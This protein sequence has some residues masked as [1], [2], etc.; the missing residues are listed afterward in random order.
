M[1]TWRYS[2]NYGPDGEA[3][4]ANVHAAD[5]Q[6]VGNLRTHHAI[7]ICNAFAVCDK[8]ASIPSGETG[9]QGWDGDVGQEERYL[10]NLLEDDR[11]TAEDLHRAMNRIRYRQLS[12]VPRPAVT[13]TM[14]NAAWNEAKDRRMTGLPTDF[15][16]VLEAALTDK[17]YDAM[18]S[19][20]PAPAAGGLEA[21]REALVEAEAAFEAIRIILVNELEEPVRG[22]FWRAV[23]ARD[24]SRAALAAAAASRGEDWRPVLTG[25]V[26]AMNKRDSDFGDGEIP[27][28]HR[29]LMWRAE[30]LL[31]SPAATSAETQDDLVSRAE[32][33]RVIRTLGDQDADLALYGAADNARA[34]E[35]GEA[36]ATR[37]CC[38]IALMPRALASPAETQG[39]DGVRE[40]LAGLS[41]FDHMMACHVG[42][43]YFDGTEITK[44]WDRLVRPA[45]DRL[46]SQ[47]APST[48]AA[49][50]GGE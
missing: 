32:V 11:L 23:Q 7:A 30:Q 46:K 20:T 31:A 9:A 16:A 29:S 42:I 10:L 18:L 33:I 24:A 17:L 25:M 34:R 6:F 4:Y 8:L 43:G 26:A 1:T 47:L 37:A 28:A 35:Y 40:M 41:D 5:G 38:A 45:M 50:R 15:R 27:S 13:T 36:A 39:G 12:G 22:A 44:E 21:V 19:A 14:V 2:I 48:S 49:T 3:N